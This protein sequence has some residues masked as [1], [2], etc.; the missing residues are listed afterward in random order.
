MSRPIE[1]I[2]HEEL[3]VTP[4]NW[5]PIGRD[6]SKHQR[7]VQYRRDVLQYRTM[8]S[9]FDEAFINK[10]CFVNWCGKTNA[11][12]DGNMS[13]KD[14]RKKLHGVVHHHHSNPMYH[15]MDPFVIKRWVQQEEND[16]FLC[17]IEAFLSAFAKWL[18][19]A[20]QQEQMQFLVRKEDEKG[21]IPSIYT[22][23]Q[24]YQLMLQSTTRRSDQCKTKTAYEYLVKQF[25]ETTKGRN[26]QSV[27]ASDVIKY[28]EK[29][30]RRNEY[31]GNC[32]VLTT[33][34][35]ISRDEQRG[36][37]PLH[38]DLKFKG[39]LMEQ[40]KFG[41]MA[42]TDNCQG[43]VFHNVGMNDTFCPGVVDPDLLSRTVWYQMPESLRIKMKE[44]SACMKYLKEYGHL[45]F[46]TKDN[47]V[48][49]RPNMLP[50][51]MHIFSACIPHHAPASV[52]ER[53]VLFCSLKPR[54]L[55][56]ARGHEEDNQMSKQKLPFALWQALKPDS[57][58]CYEDAQNDSDFV[59]LLSKSTEYIMEELQKGCY[60]ETMELEFPMLWKGGLG[61]NIN[62]WREMLYLEVKIA[63]AMSLDDAEIGRDKMIGKKLKRKKLKM[64]TT[65]AAKTK[66]RSKS[67]RCDSL[68]G[69]GVDGYIPSIGGNGCV[70]Q[71][72]VVEDI[73]GYE[74]IGDGCV[75]KV[76]NSGALARRKTRKTVGH[77]ISRTE[78]QL[79]FG[80]SL[81]IG[82]RK[83]QTREEGLSDGGNEDSD[84]DE[85]TESDNS[86]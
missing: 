12:V 77:I 28:L 35:L 20:K 15:H 46:A 21:L 81:I 39:G 37:Q 75:E 30:V 51:D 18:C 49:G 47:E 22:I 23:N 25:V 63:T 33:A 6:C 19:K 36:P 52:G 68:N 72:K 44:S 11:W 13:V 86:M 48:E 27:E 34:V 42:L 66:H 65:T 58:I 83:A 59:Y 53:A 69:T 50:F 60:D 73:Y 32:D 24:A 71:K 38:C 79:L 31:A 9:V 40:E 61:R 2:K 64:A 78:Q 57:D 70:R 80:E 56:D 85:D 55:G 67:A 8:N 82:K 54:S 29:T 45:L 84:W 3:D 26:F 17:L 62:S 4:N 76:E 5:I 16:G 43:T 41:I 74:G 14:K 7:V 10:Y 1:H